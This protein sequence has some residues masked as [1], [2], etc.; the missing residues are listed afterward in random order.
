M[1]TR[2]TPA[3]KAA[4]KAKKRRRQAEDFRDYNR[5]MVA[6]LLRTKGTGAF[7]V[8]PSA[9]GAT[10]TPSQIRNLRPARNGKV[11]DEES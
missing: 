1:F 4:D 5:K 2:R 3:E 6:K 9:E 8:V 10:A 7:I 11:T